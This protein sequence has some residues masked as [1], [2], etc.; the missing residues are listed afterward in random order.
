MTQLLWIFVRNNHGATA[1]EYAL[2][3]SI[4]AL[5]IVAAVTN[6]GVK[7]SSYFSEVSSAMK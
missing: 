2:I 1:V 6:I 4:I 7:L 5:S 3:G